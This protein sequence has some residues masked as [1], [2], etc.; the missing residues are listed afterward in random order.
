M[1]LLALLTLTITSISGCSRCRNLFRRGSPCGGTS[2]VAPGMIGAPL[3][4]R[5][6]I[7]APMVSQ[8]AC[9]NCQQAETCCDSC[10]SGWVESSGDCSECDSVTTFD[11]GYLAPGT[12]IPGVTMPEA[13]ATY[14]DPGPVGEN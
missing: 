9:S 2:M 11:D 13:P 12:V 4:I 8:P 1:I 6:P 10:E 3:G 5:A 7:A 14:A